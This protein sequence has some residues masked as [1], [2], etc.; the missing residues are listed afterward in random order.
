MIVTLK[1]ERKLTLGLRVVKTK[2]GNY[3]SMCLQTETRSDNAIGLELYAL[4]YPSFSKSLNTSERGDGPELRNK[5]YR[6]R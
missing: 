3:E 1:D 4:L 6:S 5:H 2:E